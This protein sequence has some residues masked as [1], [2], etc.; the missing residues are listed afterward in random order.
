MNN[1]FGILCDYPFLNAIQL[2][3]NTRGLDRYTDQQSL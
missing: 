1:T 3:E 2:A